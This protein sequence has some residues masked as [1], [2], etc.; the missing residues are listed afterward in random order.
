MAGDGGE[1]GFGLV[2]V[3]EL[4]HTGGAGEALQAEA[5]VEPDEADEAP[6]SG[7]VGEELPEHQMADGALPEGAPALRFDGGAEGHLKRVHVH[8]GRADG[9]AGVADEA[10]LL[11]LNQVGR[12][13]DPAVLEHPHHR[14]PPAWPLALVTGQH[15]RRTGG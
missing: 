4:E 9:G 13:R 6:E 15:V 11:V 12:Q 1:E 10:V 7:H 5:L 8:P 2:Q 14:H 3:E